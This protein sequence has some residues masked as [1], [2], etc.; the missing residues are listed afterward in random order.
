MHPGWNPAT[1]IDDSDTVVD[2]DRDLD[3][4]T[5]A[6]HVLVHAIVD[7]F[8]D[9]MMQTIDPVLPMYIAGRFRTASS[10]SST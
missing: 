1:V 7:D 3:R 4:L 2:M 10:P 5:K 6:G 9:E 8:V